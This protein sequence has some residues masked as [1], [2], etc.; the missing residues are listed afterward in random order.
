MD[1][2]SRRK[3][4]RRWGQMHRKGFVKVRVFYHDK[5]FDGAC[6]AALF[7]R[8]YRE[9]IREHAEFE[10]VGL[11]IARVRYLMKPTSPA[12]RMRLLIS[13][14]LRRRASPGGS[15]ITRARS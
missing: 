1:S 12:T 7:S 8:F 5:C 2:V 15:I 3:I 6:S 13:S 11:C 9:R 14:T 10:Y 4:R